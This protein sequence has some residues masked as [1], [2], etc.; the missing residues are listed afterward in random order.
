[1]K[2]ELW[3]GNGEFLTAVPGTISRFAHHKAM[4]DKP[5]TGDLFAS[6][7]NPTPQ[8]SGSMR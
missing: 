3:M 4:M 5:T 8:L 7:M 1:M 2:C 6:L